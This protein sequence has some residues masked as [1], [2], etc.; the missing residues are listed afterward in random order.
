VAESASVKATTHKPTPE[1]YNRRFTGAGAREQLLADLPVTERRLQLA[2]ISTAVLE[3]GRGSPVILLHGPAAHAAHWMGVIPGLVSTHRVIVPD[4]P[5]HGASEVT[6]G[7]LDVDR[8]LDWLEGLIEQTC[9]LPPV[10]VGHAFSGAIAARFAAN[11][12]R[13]SLSE[14]VLVDTLGLARFQPAPEFGHAL[15]EFLKQPNVETHRDIWR[16]CAYDLDNLLERMGERWQP[17]EAYNLDRATT[18]GVQLALSTLMELFGLSAI[19]PGEL[20]RINVPTTL[21]WGRH[22]LATPLAV[23]E[24]AST[25]YCWPLHVI[26]NCADDPPVE[27]PA[28]LLRTL[29]SIL[30]SAGLA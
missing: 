30:A 29:R 3:G 13:R 18:P 11:Y 9:K 12:R 19:S 7:S 5:G 22:D 23:A 27:Q 15:T 14:L 16:Y 2:G 1:Q 28:A 10:L 17:F 8:V 4:L 21:I 6:D 20:A 25:R 26:D 24:A